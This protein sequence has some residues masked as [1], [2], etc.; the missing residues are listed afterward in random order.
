[1]K[2]KG[3][4]LVLISQFFGSLMNVATKLLETS[5]ENDIG[6]DPF[7]VSLQK[8]CTV[9]TLTQKKILLVRMSITTI[10]CLI[11]MWWAQVPQAP[12]GSKEI[13]LLLVARGMAGTVGGL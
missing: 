6:M 13:R 5:D 11:Y 8:R 2:N 12:I 9:N 3:I 7:Q 10:L 4:L 1:M